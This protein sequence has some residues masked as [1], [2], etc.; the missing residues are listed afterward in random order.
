MLLLSTS[1]H[2]KQRISLNHTCASCEFSLNQPLRS[3]PCSTST[4]TRREPH[5]FLPLNCNHAGGQQQAPFL[6]PAACFSMLDAPA[7]ARSCPD[8]YQSPSPLPSRRSS[9]HECATIH[10]ALLI[11]S[12]RRGEP[13]A[14]AAQYRRARALLPRARSASPRPHQVRRQAGSSSA[15]YR[16]RMAPTFDCIAPPARSPPSPTLDRHS[17]GRILAISSRARRP[18]VRIPKSSAPIRR[19]VTSSASSRQRHHDAQ[20]SSGPTRSDTLVL[21]PGNTRLNSN[22]RLAAAARNSPATAAVGASSMRISVDDN[23]RIHP[24][25]LRPRPAARMQTIALRS[26]TLRCTGVLGAR[27]AINAAARGCSQRSQPSSTVFNRRRFGR[28]VVALPLNRVPLRSLDRHQHDRAAPELCRT[29][30]ITPCP[31]SG[32]LGLY[33]VPR[34]S[35]AQMHAAP[36]IRT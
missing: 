9:W 13:F 10:S 3:V 17:S 24:P 22:S 21:P 5:C 30:T 7:S 26:R 19:L 32:L 27:C 36:G 29:R 2:G 1:S 14:L 20:C 11:R 31:R 18:P 4:R 28:A 23:V 35:F 6:Q 25:A 15:P 33:T 12:H 34:Q 8:P 16:C